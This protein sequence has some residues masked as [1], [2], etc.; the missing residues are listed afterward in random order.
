MIA[1][2]T[3][4]ERFGIGRPVS[5]LVRVTGG[6]THRLFRLT[7]D[8]G[9]WAVKLLNSTGE[10]GWLEAMARSA[11]LELLAADA[12]VAVPTPAIPSDPVAVLVAEMSAGE[13]M[14]YVRVSRWVDG[15][16]S[17]AP[18]P[19]DICA[20][21]GT[22]LAQV[23]ALPILPTETV[24]EA[25]QTHA[26]ARWQQWADE[27]T[28]LGLV[29]AAPLRRSLP[30]LA[31]A[32]ALVLEATA[33]PLDLRMAHNDANPWNVLVSPTGPWLLDWDAAGA[34]VP[35]FDLLGSVWRFA[36][37]STGRPDVG[38]VRAALQA[39]EAAGGPLGRT[40]ELAFGGMVHGTMESL[41]YFLERALGH[42]DVTPEEQTSADTVTVQ[43]LEALHVELDNLSAWSRLLGR[44]CG[45]KDV[46]PPQQRA[47]RVRL[48][49]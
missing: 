15:V 26:L 31:D 21:L 10:A 13:D 30:A 41:S 17:T 45:I 38:R 22:T 34:D 42:Q 20:W 47:S 49:A 33:G 44:A 6:N 4:A 18:A 23:A 2:D 24:A 48:G 25:F 39:Y 37:A 3:V 14:E 5:G 16:I 12:G 40:D 32:G 46:L 35:W 7:T 11:E 8:Q 28:G 36:G 1:A 29:C 43:C 27:A 9:S 19:V